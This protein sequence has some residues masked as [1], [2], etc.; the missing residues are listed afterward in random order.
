MARRLGAPEGVEYDEPVTAVE[1][2]TLLPSGSLAE[3]LPE[4]IARMA[5]EAHEGAVVVQRTVV[6]H[7]WRV[8]GR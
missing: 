5:A 1:W 8:A 2:A 3:D 6:Y 7:P 4:E